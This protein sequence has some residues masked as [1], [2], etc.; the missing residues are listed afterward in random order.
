MIHSGWP[1][2]IANGAQNWVNS[3]EIYNPLSNSWSNTANF[4]FSNFGD[5]PTMLLD[6]GKPGD[7]TQVQA[8]LRHWQLDS[9]LAGL[10]E[11]AQLPAG[12]QEVCRQLWADVEALLKKAQEK[13]K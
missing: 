7:R 13:T 9:D 8:Q 1:S 12:E 11:T 5:D 3:G 10:R 4:P 6:S 2:Q